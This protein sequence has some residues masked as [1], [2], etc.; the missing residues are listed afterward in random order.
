MLMT[1]QELG[2]HTPLLSDIQFRAISRPEKRRYL[3][4]IATNKRWRLNN[5]YKI[6]NEKGKVV[7]FEMRDAQ[8]ELFESSHTFE[9]ILKARQLGF[10]TYIDIYGLDCCLFTKNF[11]AGIIAQDLESAGAIFATKVM[12]PYDNLPSYL[13]SRKPLK[14]RR[15]GANGGT[16]KFTNGSSISVRTSFRSGTLQ[17]LHISELGRICAGFPLRAKEIQ[18]GSMPTVHEGSKLFIESTAEGAAGLFFDLCKDAE[19]RKQ[20]NIPLGAKDFNFRFI[21]WFTHPNYHSP[22][23]IGGLK[24][25]KYFIEYFK[26]VDP[27]ALEHTGRKLTDTQKQWYIET[28]NKYG[29]HTKQEYPSTP[30]EA[31]L[32]SGRRVFNPIDC[33]KAEVRCCKP[34]LVYDVDPETGKM[35]DARDIVQ[36]DGKKE[37][38]IKGLM[39]YLL[40]WELPD[41]DMDY[42]IGGDI[43]EGLEHNDRSSFDVLD[44][45]GKQVAH[46]YG[47]LDTDLFAKLMA[48]IGFF[49]NTA[50]IGP[51]RNN[52]GHAI[53]N[54][55]RDI[56]PTSRIYEEEHHD[57]DDKQERT[58][59]LGWLTTR[60]SKPIIIGNLKEELRHE[61]D[62]IQWIGTVSEMNTYVYDAKGATNAIQGSFDDQVMSYAIALEMVVRMPR[63]PRK[64]YEPRASGGDY[65][66]H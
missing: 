60:K 2:D 54:V 55:L 6:E 44:E 30:Q 13:K 37:D 49:Y 31:F 10:S 26:A 58:D 17:F 47:H 15:G 56:Y 34:L 20:A 66:K 18:T 35:I 64:N 3:R 42:A 7:T 4:F 51:E 25:S 59:R 23:P 52:H 53:I 61:R 32:T 8:R 43:A 39:G 33:M 36:R 63:T 21:P 5:L 14:E 11:K 41:P 12:F 48:H 9:L 19:E 45:N 24:L 1:S 38:V 50:F 46:W 40:V 28:Y 57:K 22:V 27:Y 65:R 62:G 16:M 29:E